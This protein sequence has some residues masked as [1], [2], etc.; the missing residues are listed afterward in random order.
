M[1]KSLRIIVWLLL[2]CTA[3]AVVKAQDVDAQGNL[4]IVTLDKSRSMTDTSLGYKNY[5][6]NTLLD[7]ALYSN[8]DFTKDAFVF[9]NSGLLYM[10]GKNF[11]KS[12]VPHYLKR[13]NRSK[14]EFR[15]QFIRKATRRNEPLQFANANEFERSFQRIYGR[16][17][18]KNFPYATSFVSLIQ[19]MTLASFLEDYKELDLQQY[20]QIIVCSITDDADQT[21]QWL[22]D[23]KTVRKF[24]PNKQHEIDSTLNTLIY[25]SF[26]A[27]ST[28]RGVFSEVFPPI[29]KNGKPKLFAYA[30][31]TKQELNQSKTVEKTITI[32]SQKNDTL[33]L[34]LNSEATQHHIVKLD[35]IVVNNELLQC[36]YP[37]ILQKDSI[38]YIPAT[39]HSM[40]NNAIS[41][42]GV[43]QQMYTDDVLG[44]RIRKEIINE[45]HTRVFAVSSPL[46]SASLLKIG[47]LLLIVLFLWIVSIVYRRKLPKCIIVSPSGEV[48]QIKNGFKRSATKQ[49]IQYAGFTREENRFASVR[50]KH[51]FVSYSQ[52]AVDTSSSKKWIA[53]LSKKN[54]LFLND[55]DV[56]QF[57]KRDTKHIQGVET[58]FHAKIRKKYGKKYTIHFIAYPTTNTTLNFTIKNDRSQNEYHIHTAVI[59]D[60]AFK[61]ELTLQNER[62]ISG[63]FLKHEISTTEEYML[64]CNK[65]KNNILFINLLQPYASKTFSPIQLLKQYKIELTDNSDIKTL[66][67]QE[68]ILLQKE[69]KQQGKKGKLTT[70]LQDEVGTNQLLAIAHPF[71]PVNLSLSSNEDRT[72][73]IRL[74]LF[75]SVNY[76]KEKIAKN[77]LRIKIERPTNVTIAPYSMQ[78]LWHPHAEIYNMHLTDRKQYALN[79]KHYLN[80]GN[81]DTITLDVTKNNNE[82]TIQC[83]G[84]TI[85]TNVQEYYYKHI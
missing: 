3:T 66:L 27:N 35:A 67:Q 30:Y 70:Y 84:Q 85:K 33:T 25:N 64:L 77:A 45:A 34:R 4:W 81:P 47:A 41:L 46:H 11:Q 9:Y 54:L 80:I 56:F 40:W 39:L 58:A 37:I 36:T 29:E 49:K 72:T 55:I 2:W 69:L 20:H 18:T 10:P 31:N 17:D 59:D 44:K 1:Y 68:A 32:N 13:E 8:I 48:T 52:M 38:H 83:Q 65:T 14:K 62:M 61:T 63:F 22:Q 43:G 51:R 79:G 5:V 78:L 19:P 73:N 76:Q 26:N 7:T 28:G 12:K 21:D 6:F 15:K 75:N 71:F 16:W 74:P 57:Q 24:M 23:Y 60:E 50:L 82:Y 42:H 53:V